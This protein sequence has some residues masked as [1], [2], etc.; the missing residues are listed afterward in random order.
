MIVNLDRLAE[1]I[2]WRFGRRDFL[3][4]IAACNYLL[5]ADY[6]MQL[7]QKPFICAKLYYILA[8]AIYCRPAAANRYLIDDVYNMYAYLRQA[9]ELC[10]KLA[11]E[12]SLDIEKK[13]CA[14]FP[15]VLQLRGDNKGAFIAIEKAIKKY[16]DTGELL[17]TYAILRRRRDGATIDTVIAYDKAMAANKVRG[18]L[19]YY[20]VALYGG[21]VLFKA[22]LGVRC[23]GDLEA[24]LRTFQRLAAANVEVR[25]EIQ[26]VEATLGQ[27]AVEGECPL[28]GAP[29][30]DEIL[31][32]L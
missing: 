27:W 24:S 20:G 5:S 19:Y 32:F 2:E 9:S 14:L 7:A 8:Y 3:F 28:T 16:P 30:K 26:K 18:N 21:A 10:K 11:T 1:E 29:P 25:L 4:V 15:I 6:L 12:E 23:T 13:L 17:L 31:G 22:F